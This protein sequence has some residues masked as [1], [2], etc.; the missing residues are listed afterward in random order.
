MR[1]M[2]SFSRK[3]RIGKPETIFLSDLMQCLG[4]G[5]LS[6]GPH[7]ESHPVQ[8]TESKL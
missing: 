4:N 7:F 6:C 1:E 8:S 2:V 5:G 3:T